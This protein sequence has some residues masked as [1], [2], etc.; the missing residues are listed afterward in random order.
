MRE[1]L[2]M[3]FHRNL[4]DSGGGEGIR[5]KKGEGFKVLKKI[6]YYEKQKS[7]DLKN[8]LRNFR[9]SLNKL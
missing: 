8:W 6:K 3:P 9:L 1:P 2:I 7:N 5:A 4:L